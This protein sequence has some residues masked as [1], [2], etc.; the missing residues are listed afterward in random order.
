MSFEAFIDWRG[1]TLALSAIFPLFNSFF[2]QSFNAFRILFWSIYTYQFI[3]WLFYMKFFHHFVLNL[4]VILCLLFIQLK[5]KREKNQNKI[6]GSTQWIDSEMNWFF[7]SLLCGSSMLQYWKLN[8]KTDPNIYVFA[9]KFFLTK[10]F[11]LDT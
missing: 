5:K 7:Q 8:T 11:V 6:M 9:C 1:F 3:Y 2:L 4:L 10:W